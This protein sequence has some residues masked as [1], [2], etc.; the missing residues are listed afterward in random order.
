MTPAPHPGQSDDAAWLAR[1]SELL[2]QALGEIEDG[3]DAI[4]TISEAEQALRVA[5]GEASS[6]TLVEVG[7]TCTCPPELAARGGFSSSCEACR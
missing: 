1:A 3:V 7:P 2:T 4:A 5:Y 6:D